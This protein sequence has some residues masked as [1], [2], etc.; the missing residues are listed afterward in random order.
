VIRA[1]VVVYVVTLVTLC[2]G[3]AVW[4][5]TMLPT[6]RRALGT[7]LAATPAFAPAALFYLLYAAGVATLVVL[8]GVA[9]RRWGPVAARGALFGL[10]AYG[11][12]DLTN[13]AT[14]RDW[15]AWLTMVDMA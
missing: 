15:P 11:T 3:D 5:S 9:A 12:Y 10:V 4:L 14:L 2:A 8:P 6:Y 1:A 7:L 13:Q